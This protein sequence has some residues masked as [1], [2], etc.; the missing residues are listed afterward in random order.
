MGA[1]C[2][3]ELTAW[4][5][6]CRNGGQQRSTL[7]CGHGS[8]YSAPAENPDPILPILNDFQEKMEM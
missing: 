5:G 8:H 4:K 6:L 7:G 1:K 2:K 3:H